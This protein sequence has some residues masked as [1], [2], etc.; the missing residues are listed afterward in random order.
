MAEVIINIMTKHAC[1]P[2]TL[3]SDKSTAFMSHVIKEVAGFFG[4]I[5]KQATTKPAK[6]TI[7]LLERSHSSIKQALNIET[8]ERK[9][10]WHKYVSITV[11][12]YDTSC[13]ASIG[14]EPSR[15]FLGRIPY[16]V[17]DLKMGIL[18]QKIPAPDSQIAQDMIEWK[19]FTKMSAKLPCK[20]I[21][22]TKRIMI[23]KTNASVPKQADYV[24]V[25]QPKENH[26][27]GEIPVTDFL[28]IG[29]YII[30]KVLANNTYLVCKI[31]KCFREWDCANW[32]P[33]NHCRIYK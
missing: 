21:L 2:T 7:G 22:N 19:W 8:G 29:P 5:L 13:H 4:I 27:G 26:Q 33:G 20:L 16:N 11:P 6:T 18:P 30:E 31:G 23:K 28:W 14:C 32:H 3:S 10:L 1:L 9:S 15:V 12:N 25:L 24:Y 17:L